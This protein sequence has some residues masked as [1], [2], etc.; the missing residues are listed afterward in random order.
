M[1]D[2]TF[3][4]DTV[5]FY[6][7]YCFLYVVIFGYDSD[8][9]SLVECCLNDSPL[10]LVIKLTVYLQH[11]FT[12]DE[13]GWEVSAYVLKVKDREGNNIQTWPRHLMSRTV[14]WA[15][16]SG[17]Q[18]LT[19][20]SWMQRDPACVSTIRT[21][22]LYSVLYSHVLGSQ[23]STPSWMVFYKEVVTK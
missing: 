21:D 11:W 2:N 4:L 8:D 14:L 22:A 23:N 13:E 17:G 18:T 15:L 1:T 16:D 12:N 19:F 7:S 10:T 6:L 5:E 20:V 9:I 3:C